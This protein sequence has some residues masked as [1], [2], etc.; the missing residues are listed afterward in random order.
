MSSGLEEDEREMARADCRL[1][2]MSSIATVSLC[3]VTFQR[4]TKLLVFGKGRCH[5]S[6]FRHK[7]KEILQQKKIGRNSSC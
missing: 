2:S 6:L 1:T 5:S 7:Y 3:H 4:Q